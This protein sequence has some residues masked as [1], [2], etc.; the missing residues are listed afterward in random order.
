MHQTYRYDI[1]IYAINIPLNT[2]F[3]LTS[4]HVDVKF[5]VNT[6]KDAVIKPDI[7]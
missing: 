2:L 1:Y 6:T 7:E 4:L 3:Y 5:E